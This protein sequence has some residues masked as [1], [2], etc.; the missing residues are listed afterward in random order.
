[1]FSQKKMMKFVAVA[2][3]V[4]GMLAL[5][6]G[7][8]VS[9]LSHLKQRSPLGVT[10]PASRSAWRTAAAKPQ[11][12][13]LRMSEDDKEEKKKGEKEEEQG[14]WE[15]LTAD[16]REEGKGNVFEQ[17][18]NYAVDVFT[19]TAGAAVAMCLVFNLFGKIPCI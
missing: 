5:A 14:V 8:S 7:F 6:E 16:F 13:A 18:M 10:R 2:V 17:V 3:L 1:M 4:A 11:S 15:K 12:V 9:S 19:V